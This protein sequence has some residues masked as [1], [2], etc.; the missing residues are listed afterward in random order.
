MVSDGGSFLDTIDLVH[1][2]MNI[3]IFQGTAAPIK[4]KA[5]VLWGEDTDKDLTFSIDF[6]RID[7]F[8]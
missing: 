7:V 3:K 2:T 8:R 4:I 5:S 1:K 6:P